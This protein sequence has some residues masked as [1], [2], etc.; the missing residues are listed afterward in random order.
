MS[1]P[2]KKK[3]IGG[4]HQSDPG[5]IGNTVAG[6]PSSKHGHNGS[7]FYK[8]GVTRNAKKNRRRG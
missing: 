1:V 6:N 4:S 5:T 7:G 2:L 3:H 8:H